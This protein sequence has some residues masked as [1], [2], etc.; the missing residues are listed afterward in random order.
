MTDNANSNHHNQDIKDNETLMDSILLSNKDI[1]LNLILEN[2]NRKE[3]DYIVV[4]E[5]NYLEK[6]E[7]NLI[8]LM[9][10]IPESVMKGL[11]E[12]LESSN[13]NVKI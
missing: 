11:L 1:M 9:D 6:I 12:D 13:S 3:K 8:T 4:K 10:N 7:K 5:L 2:L